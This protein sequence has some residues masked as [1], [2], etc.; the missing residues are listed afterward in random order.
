MSVSQVKKRFS[1]FE[2]YLGRD[3]EALRRLKLLK[4]DVNVLRTS[5]AAAEEK[6]ELAE[7]VKNAARERADAAEMEVIAL[8]SEV[9]R[10]KNKTDSLQHENAMLS[11]QLHEVTHRERIPFA[12]GSLTKDL[13]PG[14]I[15]RWAYKT[16]MELGGTL[17]KPGKCTTSHPIGF[18]LEDILTG[19]DEY[20]FA[21]L[22]RTIVLQLL[23]RKAVAISWSDESDG[24]DPD[25]LI[26]AIWK[27]E[28]SAKAR[29]TITQLFLHQFDRRSEAE[30]LCQKTS[31]KAFVPNYDGQNA[32]DI[33]FGTTGHQ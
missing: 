33:I 27:Q 28:H 11:T 17:V 5:L 10:L 13:S 9:E 22:G 6:A 30:I 2:S 14:R 12:S 25:K 7:V 1:E 29:R 31:G 18:A 3:K 32:I 15:H 8:S 24:V 26:A 21:T 20:G 23:I 19:F 16:L 4:D